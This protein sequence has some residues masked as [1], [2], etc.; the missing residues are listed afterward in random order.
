[1][2]FKPFYIKYKKFSD[3]TGTLI[4]FYTRRS[5]PNFFK[6]KRFFFL[7]GKKKYFRA[8]HAHKKCYQIIIP[9][10]GQI[11]ITTF[12][13]K[14]KKIFLL[15]SRNNKLLFIPTY[16]WLKIKFY[17]TN[18]CLLTLCNFKYD[19]KEYINDFNE[20]NKKYF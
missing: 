8:D 16:T 15:N 5:F 3:K 6:I 19:K 18:D 12:F 1:M 9:I 13:N 7:Y 14:K 2:K 11:K 17:S 20:F 10:K 4:P